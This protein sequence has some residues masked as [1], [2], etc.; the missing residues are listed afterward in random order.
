MVTGHRPPAAGIVNAQRK[1]SGFFTAD[2]CK[3]GPRDRVA[4]CDDVTR[5]ALGCS[6]DDLRI[7]SK[8][9]LYDR[10]DKPAHGKLSYQLN[11]SCEMLLLLLLLL[12]WTMRIHMR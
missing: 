12:Q 8:S 3:P 1:R 2:F 9:R 7:K 6:F 4:D 10:N 5:L 11:E